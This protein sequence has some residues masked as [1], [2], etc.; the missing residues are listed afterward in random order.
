MAYRLNCPCG[1]LLYGR[2]EDDMV[3]NASAHAVAV[4]GRSYAP[5]EIMLMAVA[6]PE[7]F[8]PSDS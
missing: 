2:T 3:H 5:H 4:H 7:S 1:E 8:L 6:I